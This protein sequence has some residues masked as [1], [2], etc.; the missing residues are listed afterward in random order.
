LQLSNSAY[1]LG[2]VSFAAAVPMLA[3]TLFG[4]VIADHVDKRRLL[5]ATQI[6]MMASAFVLSIL[7][8]FH[9]VAVP[10]I[11]VLAFATGLATALS[12]P[13]YQALVPQLVSR[14]ELTNAVGL[15][16][17]QFNMSRVLGPTIGG[18]TM[19]WVGMA[20]NFFL[21]GLSFLAVIYALYKMH[22]PAQTGVSEGSLWQRLG[23]GFRHV[24]GRSDT[25]IMVW[26]VCVAALLG[27]PYLSFMP[28]F[29]RDV[30]HVEEKGLGLLMAFSGLGAFLGA[31]TIAY[32]H[33][34]RRRGTLIL[35][36]G[37]MFFLAIAGFCYSESFT[38]SAFLQV[39]AGYSMIIMVAIINTRLQHLV[40]DEMRGRTM[41]IYS[42]AYLGL[43]PIGSFLAGW[44][45]KYVSAPH[46]IAAM[47][48][49]GLVIFWLMF[50]LRPDLR[51]LD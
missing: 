4:G 20:G 39:V 41:S 19:A 6:A 21:N 31:V 34:P 50:V 14:S 5:I 12:A 13:S 33:T 24:F 16:S 47:S 1:W 18:L 30:L 40:D 36:S 7:T 26:V 48:A 10:H 37:T 45:T 49:A 17:A 3:F 28:Y 2:V 38:V 51:S 8:Y 15:N 27:I 11:I 23:E 32:L 35:V 46:A 44:L 9:R 29:A 25:N 22:Y 43:P 42:T